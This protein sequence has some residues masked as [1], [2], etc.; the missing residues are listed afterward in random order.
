MECDKK[1]L[2]ELSSPPQKK[3]EASKYKKQST[4]WFYGISDAE[5]KAVLVNCL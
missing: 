1:C 5:I 4:T 2:L 3:N